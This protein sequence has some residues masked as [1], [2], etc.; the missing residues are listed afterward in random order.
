M[1]PMERFSLYFLEA[2]E[3]LYVIGKVQN[4]LI[5]SIGISFMDMDSILRQCFREI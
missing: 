2:E 3:E 5:T 1:N 4:H